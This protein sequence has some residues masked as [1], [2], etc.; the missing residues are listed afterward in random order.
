MTHQVIQAGGQ[1]PATKD[2]KAPALAGPQKA[3]IIIQMILS[4][5]G[6]IPLSSLSS[7]G[8]T[9]LM[10]D[11]VELGRVDRATLAAVVSDLERDMSMVG[12]SFPRS[13]SDALET[14]E[15]HLSPDLV[16]DLRGQLGLGAPPAPWARIAKLQPEVLAGLLPD[17]DPKIAAIVLSKL[18]PEKA[19]ELLDKMEPEQATRVAMAMQNTAQLSPEM[20]TEIGSMLASAI[21]VEKPKAFSDAPALRVANLLNAASPDRRDEVLA[22]LSDEDADFANQVRASIFTFADIATRIE[23]GDIAKV[24][25]DVP[26]EELVLALAYGKTVEPASCDFLLDNLS[27]RM[28]A[29]LREEIEEQGEV[30]KKSGEASMG[31]ITSAIRRL[32]DSG[33]IK[34]LPPPGSEEPEGAE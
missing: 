34:I 19:S 13:V 5:G 31:R 6:S 33:E 15:A 23:A 25:R 14:L 22:S 12:L 21:P 10:Q 3:A 11:F 28:A 17:E 7:R 4:E 2:D 32:A 26:Q 30:P 8:Q 20:V 16:T 9:R 24:T 1:M 18:D 29:A 27:Q